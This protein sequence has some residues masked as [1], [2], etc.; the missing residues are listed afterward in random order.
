MQRKSSKQRV[1]KEAEEEEE[2]AIKKSGERHCHNSFKYEGE[3][4]KGMK[5]TRKFN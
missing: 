4:R 2:E 5:K 3:G 1:R